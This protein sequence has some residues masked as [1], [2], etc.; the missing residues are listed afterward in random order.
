MAD[1]RGHIAHEGIRRATL[2][3]DLDVKPQ[4]LSVRLSPSGPVRVTLDDLER[5]A[6]A[7]G[8]HVTISIEK[9]A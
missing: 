1:L 6:D 3:Q 5:I 9:A 7:L 2:A 4:W 8:L